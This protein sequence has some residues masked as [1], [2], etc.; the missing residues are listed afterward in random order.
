MSKQ[1][2]KILD[3]SY[4]FQLNKHLDKNLD[5]DPLWSSKALIT[6]PKA[7]IATHMDYIKGGFIC[8]VYIII[9]NCW[10]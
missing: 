8:I 4:G 2:I 3:G 5:D 10:F 1:N 6:N 9:L 7:V